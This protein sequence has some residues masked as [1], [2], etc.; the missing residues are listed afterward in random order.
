MADVNLERLTV[1]NNLVKDISQGKLYIEDFYKDNGDPKTLDQGK[2]DEFFLERQN[3]LT[4]Y[5]EGMDYII[6]LGESVYTR[7]IITLATS[8]SST[9]DNELGDKTKIDVRFT[10]LPKK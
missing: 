2:Y 10:K 8:I 4:Q 9:I 7:E 6:S 1:I 5:K 3:L